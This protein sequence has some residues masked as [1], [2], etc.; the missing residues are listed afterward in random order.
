MS[1]PIH[2]TA[3]D[4]LAGLQEIPLPSPVPYVPE[5]IG[6]LAIAAVLV[7]M[8]AWTIWR[9][10]RYR[11]ANAYRR[12][13]LEELDRLE[14]TI[15]TDSATCVAL[16][17][18]LKRT[19]MAAGSREQAASLSGQEWLQFLDRTMNTDAFS[20]GSGRL[21]TRIT[22]CEPSQLARIPAQDLQQLVRLSRRWI[23]HH[24]VDV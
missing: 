21:L 24:D 2:A 11:R 3:V 10:V 9:I 14:Q 13:A 20:R 16:P 12:A 7:L 22:Y 23:R 1:E 17:A 19:A 18:L 6:W 8:A 5:T 4:A 15:A